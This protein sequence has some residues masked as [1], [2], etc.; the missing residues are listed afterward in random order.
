MEAYQNAE[1]NKEEQRAAAAIHGKTGNKFN[2]LKAIKK[3]EFYTDR[4]EAVILSKLGR[5][6]EMQQKMLARGS[7]SDP[8]VNPSPVAWLG[9]GVPH[10][11]WLKNSDVREPNGL[12]SRNVYKW[13]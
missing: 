11:L 12:P 3:N 10:E 13:H 9:D 6:R 5:A 4:M 2:Y 7:L 1:Q 8:K